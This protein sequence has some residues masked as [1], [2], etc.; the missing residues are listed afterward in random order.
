MITVKDIARLAGVSQGTV[1]NVLNNRGNVSAEKIQRVTE[2]AKQL[3]YVA[4]AQAKQLRQDIPLSTHV[5]IILPNIDEKRYS[6]FFNGI[7]LLLEERGYTPLLFVTDDSPYKEEQIAKH[8]AEMRVS[9]VITV[10]GSISHVDIYQDA[11]SSGAEVL[12][13]FRSVNQSHNFI[14]FDFHSIGREIGTYVLKQDYRHVAVISDPECY[15]ENRDFIS[16]LRETIQTARSPRRLQIKTA[17]WLN[18]SVSPFDF[19]EGNQEAPDV[20]ILTNSFFLPKVQLAFSVASVQGCPPIIAISGDSIAVENPNVTRY[21]LD[22]LHAGMRAAQCLLSNLTGPK[23]EQREILGVTGFH[24]APYRVGTSHSGTKLRVLLAKSESSAA[25]QRITP[26]F[27]RKTGIEVEFV[28]LLPSEVFSETIR[29]S[30]SGEFDLVRSNMSCLPLFTDDLFYTFTDEEFQ[31]ITQGM[32]PRIVK[33]FSYIHGKPQ[34]IPFDI[35]ID[36]L[37]YRKDLFENQLLKRMYFEQTGE[38]LS[39]PAT[40]DQYERIIR[41]FSRDSNPQ[42]PVQAGTGMNWDSPTELSSS[43]FLRYLNYMKGGTFRRGETKVEEAAV[44]QTLRNMYTCGQYALPVQ[45]KR[46]VGATLDNFIYGQTAVELVFLNYASNIAH[47]QKNIYGGKV[48]YTT[49]PGG[50]SYITGGSFSIFKTSSQTEAT[51]EFIRW[52]SSFPQTELLTLYGGLSPYAEVYRSSEILMQYPWYS[53]LLE[54]LESAR[55]REVW[56]V[57]DQNRSSL[58]QLPLLQSIVQG[59]RTPEDALPQMMDIL[60]SALLTD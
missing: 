7:K 32:L 13:A 26:G 56:D 14:G 5:A 38:S 29:A 31:Q 10:T 12:Y 11:L 47:L 39:V 18:I 23:R 43:F 45:G 22:Y 17:D 48:G 44:L 20:I 9:G 27:V 50:I 46:W 53:H 25:L 16:G 58:L 6:S 35:G 59:Q 49:V 33:D 1:S 37:V 2:A 19:F 42:S 55:G 60:E 36:M 51:K 57:F 41:F 4:N 21:S 3:G 52:V 8:V 28:E 40:F 24:Q 15:P 30:Q 34:A 54:N